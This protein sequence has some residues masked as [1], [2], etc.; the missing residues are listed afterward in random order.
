M[1]AFAKGE[2]NESS[3]G[4]RKRE[5]DTNPEDYACQAEA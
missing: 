5:I 3:S 1:G 4:S 2:F